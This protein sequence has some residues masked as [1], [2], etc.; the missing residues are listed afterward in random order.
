[1]LAHKHWEATTD[2]DACF[3][4]HLIICRH[5]STHALEQ[6]VLLVLGDLYMAQEYLD[7]ATAVLMEIGE[8]MKQ[9]EYEIS[10][11]KDIQQHV[12][13]AKSDEYICSVHSQHKFLYQNDI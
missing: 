2:W 12:K 8:E 9:L 1:M 7:D 3:T 5:P 13:I 11:F 6:A 4:A 10:V